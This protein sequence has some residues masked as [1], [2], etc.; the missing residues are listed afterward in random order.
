[1]AKRQIPAKLEI[2]TFQITSRHGLTVSVEVAFLAG[3]VIYN[4]DAFRILSKTARVKFER[5][6][7][8][9]INEHMGVDARETVVVLG[10]RS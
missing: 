9:Q 10:R 7:D 1:M 8:R 2:K 4:D 6:L 5:E 3:H